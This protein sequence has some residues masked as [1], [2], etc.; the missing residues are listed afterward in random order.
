MTRRAQRISVLHGG[1]SSERPVS[2]VSGKAAAKA[3]KQSGADVTLIDMTRD[4]SALMTVLKAS[5]P[6]VVFNAL[7]GRY[8]EDGCVQGLLDMLGIP[9]TNSGRLAS[10]LAMDKPM[11]K[12]LFASAGIPVA[13]EKVVT[14]AEAEQADALPPPYVVKPT[15]EGSSVG[16]KF[17]HAGDNRPPLDDIGVPPDALVM[18]EEYI[19]GREVTVAVMGDRPLAVTEIFTDRAF[20]DYEAKYADGGSRHVLPADIEPG[21]YARAMELS[22]AAHRALGCRGVTRSDFRYDGKDFYLLELNTQPGLTP[23]SLVPEQ[24]AHVGL[25]FVGLVS[26]MVENAQCDA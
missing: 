26:W 6:D 23:T 15:N 1:F 21:P 20:Y 10:A 2:L 14:R 3:L 19:P 16:I 5:K 18:V 17:V 9:Y 4:L 13:R 22:V 8:G 12:K 11:A 7:H 25:D 24:A